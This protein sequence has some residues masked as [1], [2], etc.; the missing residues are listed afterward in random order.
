MLPVPESMCVSTSLSRV[1]TKTQE[2]IA[3]PLYRGTVVLLVN[4]GLIAGLGFIFWA[5][6]ARD[7]SAST[8]GAFSGLSSGIGIVSTIASLG[9]PNVITRHLG[10]N[11]SSLGLLLV[12]TVAVMVLGSALCAIVVFGLGSLS[13]TSLHLRQH[14]SSTVLFTALV[15]LTSLNNVYNAGLVKLRAPQAVLWTNLVGA[16]AKLA[17]VVLLASMR[18]SGIIVSFAIGLVLST[19]LSMPPLAMKA[20]WGSGLGETLDI[21]RKQSSTTFYNYIATIL[22]ILPSTVVPL[23]VIAARGEAQAAP[24]ALAFLVSGFLNVIPST[25]SGVLFAEASRN[26]ASVDQQ[27]QKAIRAI[28]GLVIP[29]VIV[30]IVAAPYVMHTFGSTYESEGTSTL[31]ILCLSTLVT[32]GNYLIDSLLLS[33]DRGIAYLFMNGANSALVLG[34]VGFLLRYGI[35][36]GSEGWALGQTASVVLGLSVLAG[37]RKRK[38]TDFE[39]AQF[40]SHL[41]AGGQLEQPYLGEGEGEAQST[42]VP[43]E[44]AKALRVL[45]SMATR[46]PLLQGLSPW[47]TQPIQMFDPSPQV[48]PP[49]QIILFGIWFPLLKVPS[50]SGEVRSARDS[51]VLVAFS[52]YSGFIS[53]ELIPSLGDVDVLAG[54]WNALIRVGGLPR[55]LVWDRAW[56]RPNYQLFFSTSGAQ[57]VPA[58][59]VHQRAIRRMCATLE[60]QLVDGKEVLF[61]NDFERQLGNLAMLYN[62]RAGHPADESPEGL[63]ITDRTAL[64]PLPPRPAVIQWR[65]DD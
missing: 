3:D 10:N 2:V 50:G 36:G 11:D 40:G 16:I 47:Q 8:V 35:V 9:L 22:G 18:S 17:G 5:L 12:A 49:G 59:E 39:N 58:N 30:A 41:V 48:A 19:V 23:E 44:V 53:A 13:S 26:G 38:S 45:E 31:R 55:Y 60:K 1:I 25:T 37:G 57:A 28:F 52:G 14:G 61:V 24:F 27:A 15:I 32:S 63:A 7:Y 33:R 21:L 4:T 46:D 64:M 34:C 6:A 42:R 29:A 20:K 56:F 51:P 65:G 62:A 54:C 43:E